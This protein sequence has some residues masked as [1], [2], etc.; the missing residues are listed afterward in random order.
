MAILTTEAHLS[1]PLVLDLGNLG[2]RVTH[3][4]DQQVDQQD[5]DDRQEEE[6]QNLKWKRTPIYRNLESIHRVQL[7]VSIY[8]KII[9]LPWFIC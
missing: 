1:H 9:D 3:H 5:E 8:S 2:V 7:A 6:A 4:G